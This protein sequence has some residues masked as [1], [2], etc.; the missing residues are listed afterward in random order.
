MAPKRRG[1]GLCGRIFGFLRAYFVLSLYGH[2]TGEKTP[3]RASN[4]QI[5]AAPAAGG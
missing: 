4:D 3:V 1:S 2:Q 5:E